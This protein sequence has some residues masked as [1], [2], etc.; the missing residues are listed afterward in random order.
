MSSDDPTVVLPFTAT[1][2]SSKCD[3]QI[4]WGDESP[5]TDITAQPHITDCMELQ[6]RTHTY[7]KAGRYNV[8]II[9]VYDG[10]GDFDDIN[11][12][13][14][15]FV[16]SLTPAASKL[17]EVLSFGPVGLSR[18]AF[19]GAEKL[20][21]MPEIDTPDASKLVTLK[22]FFKKAL[23][24]NAPIGHWD[25]SH[26]TDMSYTFNDASAF[27]QAIGSWDTSSVTN[28]SRMFYKASNF[29]QSIDTWNTSHVTDMTYMFSEASAFNQDLFAW[30]LNTD[31][32]LRSMF[33]ASGMSDNWLC[34][35]KSKGGAWETQWNTLG[36]TAVCDGD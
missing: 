20:S 34:V 10:W 8:K 7:A 6:N 1:S 26:V 21:V 14:E 12:V 4:L 5:G 25:T 28:M 31:V 13:R 2:S 18:C 9:G 3:F 22:H 23:I 29:D 24:F 35:L 16:E 19:C 17:R 36:K 30:N 27:N 15:Q 11:I 33:R 32:K